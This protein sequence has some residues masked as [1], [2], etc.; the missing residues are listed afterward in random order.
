[1]HPHP[2][3]SIHLQPAPSSSIHLHPAHFDL[4]PAPSTSTKLIAVSNQLS[5]TP[6]TIFQP[7]YCTYL[8][9]FPKFKPKIQKLSI[10]TGNWT[11]GILEVLISNP[12]LKSRPENLFLGKS[13]S[14]VVRF[15]GR[16]VH[17]V[18]QGC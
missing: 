5:A 1:M 16:L 3:S 13:G 4:Y 17:T 6:S 8:G 18:S 7:K 11:H 9:N 10:L 12:D 2:P 15:V 14:K